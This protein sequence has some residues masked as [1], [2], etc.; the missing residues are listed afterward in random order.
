MPAPRQRPARRPRLSDT[1]TR[2]RML[3][4]AVDLLGER[5]VTVGLDGIQL[6]DV[7]RRADVSRTSAYRRWPTR[8]AFLADVLLEVA[9]GTDLPGISA[10]VTA[11]AGPVLDPRTVDVG[12]VEGRRELFVE[13]LR[14]TFQADL[15]G[16]LASPQFSAYLALR[17]AFA[18]VPEQ[19][20]R[21]AL[22]AELLVSERAA[23]ARGAVILSGAAHLLGYRL[24]APLTAPDGF[25]VVARAI[26][27]MTT[28]FVIAAQADPALV[29]GTQQQAPFGARRTA[30]WSV[31][32][33]ALA[34]LVLSHLEPDPGAP[35]V[36]AA[37]LLEELTGLV[38][39]G[40]LVA[41]AQRG[42]SP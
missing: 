22:A 9:R 14:L 21:D 1:D 37:R 32:T 34:G 25:S 15:E 39:Q 2:A 18:G 24:V 23:V 29:H 4:A 35:D 40:R 27:A 38:E 8:D 31:P 6:E 30:A 20:L 19:G 16:T 10:R 3:A 13:L 28:G 12:S 11:E 17:A 42:V 5:G 41:Q 26:S 7:I 33:F 36:D